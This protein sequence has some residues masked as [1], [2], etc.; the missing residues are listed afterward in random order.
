MLKALFEEYEKRFILRLNTIMHEFPY[1]FDLYDVVWFK[2]CVTEEQFK[3]MLCRYGI[4]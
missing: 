3:G 4:K 1:P 2:G